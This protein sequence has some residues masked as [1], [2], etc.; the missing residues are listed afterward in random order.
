MRKNRNTDW[1]ARLVQHD[2]A[3]LSLREGRRLMVEAKVSSS[4]ID[5]VRQ[6]L[7]SLE[8]ARRHCLIMIARNE[9]GP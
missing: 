1:V 6:A 8:G 9:R 3:I 2:L 4:A 5:G 7:K